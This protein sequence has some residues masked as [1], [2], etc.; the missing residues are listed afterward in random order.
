MTDVAALM[1]DMGRQGGRRRKG[2]LRWLAQK[3]HVLV[4]GA[5]IGLQAQTGPQ[6][7][8]I[9]QFGMGVQWQVVGEQVDV[10]LQQQRQPLLHPASHA[11]ILATP[12]Q[13]V[14]HQDGSGLR[15][16]C[17]LDQRTAGGDTS[18]QAPNFGPAFDLQAVGAIVA[19]QLRLQ[20]AIERLE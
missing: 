17:R 19:E 12:E 1:L 4:A 11:A 2:L 14:V 7:R 16:D 15:I 5:A 10:M 6:L 8:V 9:A 13:S 3:D 18:D 20:Q